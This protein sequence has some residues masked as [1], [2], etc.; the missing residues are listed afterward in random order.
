MN[1]TVEKKLSLTIQ[2]LFLDLTSIARR[3][4]KPNRKVDEVK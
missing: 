4:S 3:R 1:L 2:L